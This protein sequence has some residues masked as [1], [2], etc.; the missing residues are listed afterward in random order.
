MHTHTLDLGWH[1]LLHN[2]QFKAE[3]AVCPTTPADQRIL[4]YYYTLYYSAKYVT[5][6]KK[7]TESN[8]RHG[9]R[10]RFE[11]W[12]AHRKRVKLWNKFIFSIAPLLCSTPLCIVQEGHS[13]S[14]LGCLFASY[15]DKWLIHIA[16][17]FRIYSGCRNGMEMHCLRNECSY[18]YGQ[19]KSISWNLQIYFCKYM[20]C[21][22]ILWGQTL[23]CK[24]TVF[25]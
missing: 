16:V 18:T 21:A 25:I 15:M 17:V 24:I 9:R 3:V 1:L 13:S 14:F 20:Y 8:V 23:F 12:R 4:D 11:L 5:H 7:N 6:T 2:I 22:L 19:W 10:R